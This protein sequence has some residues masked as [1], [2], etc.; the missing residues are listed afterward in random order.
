MDNEKSLQSNLLGRYVTQVFAN[1]GFIVLVVSSVAWFMGEEVQES[2]GIMIL[3]G[4]GM[5]YASLLQLL[6]FAWIVTSIMFYFIFRTEKML[7]IWRI[8]I[9]VIVIVV[10]TISFIFM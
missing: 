2:G 1:F 7:L 8:T 10:A 3:A 9:Q 6:L 5:T 4:V